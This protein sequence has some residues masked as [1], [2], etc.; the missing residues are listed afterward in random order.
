MPSLKTRRPES[1]KAYQIIEVP[2]LTG[3]QDVRRSPTLLEPEQAQEMRNVSIG[4]PGE[5]TVRAGYTQYSTG[6]LGSGRAQGGQRVYLSSHTFTLVAWG[7]GVYL[8]DSTLTST[9]TPVL[10]SLSTN[11]VYF[12][13]D[14]DIVV[15]LDGSSNGQRKS[16]NGSSWTR[17]GIEA[18]S[19][20]VTASTL[21][22]GSC[23]SGE[24]EFAFSF[25]DRDLSY[26]SNISTGSTVTLS[27]T[28][29]AFHLVAGSSIGNDAQ[30]D[31]YVWYGRDITAGET[32][33]RKISSGTASTFRVTDTS[34]TLTGDE[35]PTNHD[36]P[37]VAE[38]GTPWKNRWWLKS[39]TVGNRLHFSELF[40]PQAFPATFYIDIPFERGDSITAIVPLGDV[41]VVFG[42]SK[43]YLVIGQTSLD[44]EVRPSAGAI[45]GVLGNRAWAVVE[46]GII[47]AS[48]E[49]VAIFNGAEDRYL[50]LDIEPA[51]RDYVSGASQ[52]DLA[53]TPMVY[54]FKAKELRVAV[55][56]VYP[57]ATP[58]E[59]IINLDRTRQGTPAWTNTDRSIGGYIHFDGNEAAA[60]S[61]GELLSWESTAGR[62]F[63]ESTGTSANSSN[64]VAEYT[65]PGLAMGLH[66]ARV[67]DGHLEYEPNDGAF[68]TE[69][70]IDGVSQGVVSHTIGAGLALYDVAQYDVDGYAGAGRRK[71]H[72]NLPLGAEGRVI[73]HKQ[74]YTGQSKFRMFTV[75]YGIRP[76]RRMRDFTE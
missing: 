72:W 11:Q 30:V 6:N 34:W 69:T 21:S 4:T 12:P 47:R 74:T 41:L 37:P 64:M 14:R 40:L 46:Q 55:T 15:A 26:E 53:R 24:Y 32:V 61:R 58:G 29:G 35:A 49:G 76:E 66:I 28:T 8:G 39:A 56:R 36:V 22:S 20:C 67:I 19:T 63:K 52:A 18:P 42:Q 44:F 7:Q 25:K 57:R 16:T 51:W 23:S 68:A 65:G 45:Y 3:G 75:A 70:E 71:L 17:F 62:L 31:A 43:A 50:S 60:G 73:V 10:S 1:A 2:D 27:G 13:Y 59:W 9:S 38:F 5:W 54:E 48:A 33:F